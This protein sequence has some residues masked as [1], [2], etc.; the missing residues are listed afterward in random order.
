MD[1]SPARSQPRLNFALY[2]CRTWNDL[3]VLLTIVLCIWALFYAEIVPLYQFDESEAVQS[4]GWSYV[5]ASVMAGTAMVFELLA[6]LVEY[7]SVSVKSFP[8]GVTGDDSKLMLFVYV[9][10]SV[11]YFKMAISGNQWVHTDP[12]AAGGARPVYTLRYLEWSICMPLLMAVSAGG[13]DE[14]QLKS[15]ADQQ[16]VVASGFMGQVNMVLNL[17]LLVGDR[18]LSSPLAASARCTA[19]YIWSSWLALVVD[20]EA[21]QTRSD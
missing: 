4:I 1:A 9:C 2:L 11:S 5:I 14:G 13:H 7:G 20:D 18:F 21:G 3:T 15:E 12:F 16:E 6:I 19:T 10:L 8:P 17:P